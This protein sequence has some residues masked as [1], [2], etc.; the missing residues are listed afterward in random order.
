[1]ARASPLPAVPGSGAAALFRQLRRARFRGVSGVWLLLFPAVMQVSAVLLVLPSREGVRLDEACQ[2][3]GHCPAP[4][5]QL[6][7]AFLGS[8]KFPSKEKGR[9]PQIGGVALGSKRQW[10]RQVS[11]WLQGQKFRKSK[12]L[13]THGQRWGRGLTAC[14]PSKK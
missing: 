7:A 11:R 12:K 10:P 4:A 8:V 3:P 2:V 13:L 5:L 6:S 9:C 14:P 1:M